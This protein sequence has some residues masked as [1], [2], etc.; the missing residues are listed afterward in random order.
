MLLNFS[1]APWR[2]CDHQRQQCRVD[3][4]LFGEV[5]HGVHEEDGTDQDEAQRREDLE[6]DRAQPRRLRIARRPGPVEPM[7]T[8]RGQL[9]R[10]GRGR[11]LEV[12]LDVQP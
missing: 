9:V 5:L 1:G 8:E 11:G 12:R 6:V 4:E 2:S 7:E 10:M 3:G